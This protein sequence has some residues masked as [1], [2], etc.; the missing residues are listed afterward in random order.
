MQKINEVYTTKNYESF[1]FIGNNRMV[2]TAHV[3]RIIDSMKIKRLIRPILVNEKRQI[4]DGQH[5]FLAQRELKLD[6]PFTVEE[7]YGEKEAQILNTNAKNW[8]LSDWERYYCNKNVKDYIDFS[9]FRKKYKFDFNVSYSIMTGSQ[10]TDFK[11][12]FEGGYLKISNLKLAEKNAVKIKSISKYFK[13]YKH[14]EFVR[15]MLVCFKNKEYSHN[16]FLSK[17]EYQGTSLVKC[18]NVKTY[19]R[20]IEDIYNFRN[21]AETKPLRLF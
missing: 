20:L 7:G 21:R 1:S 15:A 17:L 19:L 16:K 12:T 2:S 10:H 14:R 3:G 4:I 13:D 11:R 9:D 6:V 18:V 5:R 8:S